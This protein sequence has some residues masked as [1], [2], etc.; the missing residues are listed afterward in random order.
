MRLLFVFTILIVA[1]LGFWFVAHVSIATEDP[2]M[3][4]VV[5]I[6]SIGGLI[7]GKVTDPR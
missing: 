3:I 5:I 4:A 2:I 7:L 1:L 6:G